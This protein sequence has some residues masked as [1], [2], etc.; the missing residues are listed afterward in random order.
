M[1]THALLLM[2][3]FAAPAWAQNP[4]YPKGGDTVVCFDRP[5]IFKPGSGYEPYEDLVVDQTLTDTGLRHLISAVPREWYQIELLN[6]RS[7]AWERIKT[8]SYEQAL[9]AM[10]ARFD[11]F[12]YFS[13]KLREVHQRIRSYRAGYGTPAGRGDAFDIGRPLP[14]K[15]NCE[16]VQTAYRDEGL[17]RYD[18]RIDR[19]FTGA[20]A[21]MLQFH[22]IL[23]QYLLRAELIPDPRH[24]PDVN[25]IE[26]LLIA[27]IGEDHPPQTL[28]RKIYEYGFAS[29]V[30]HHS[31]LL[32]ADF[33][34]SLIRETEYYISYLEKLSSE[35]TQGVVPCPVKERWEIRVYTG[36]EGELVGKPQGRYRGRMEWDHGT[37]FSFHIGGPGLPMPKG[38][39]EASRAHEATYYAILDENKYEITALDNKAKLCR[40]TGKPFTLEQR[41]RFEASRDLVLTYFQPT[42]GEIR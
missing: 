6:E 24:R 19:E 33:A 31:P 17:Y 7:V 13:H 4:P 23:L 9:R 37:R 32:R 40:Y 11:E 35:A 27:A 28:N 20:M 10:F 42:E 14:L 8:L 5:P 1:K 16:Y 25:G 26:L 3:L 30:D 41:R 21:A 29:G 15:S 38:L 36:A 2:L 39:G 18:T 34:K 12:P 22:E